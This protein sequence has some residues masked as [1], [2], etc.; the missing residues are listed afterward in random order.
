MNFVKKPQV[1]FY[2]RRRGRG[3]LSARKHIS[4]DLKTQMQISLEQGTE[5]LDLSKIFHHKEIWLEIG[6][7]GGEHLVFQA[8]RNPQ[9]GFL[10]VEAFSNGVMSL[11]RWVAKEN[12]DNVRVYEGDVRLLIPCLPANSLG[13]IFILFPDP[14][15]K[16]RHHKRRLIHAQTLQEFHRILKPQGILRIASDH[17][18]YTHWILKHIEETEY[19]K[20]SATHWE[21]RIKP[22]EDWTPTRYEIKARQAGRPPV[23]LDCHPQAVSHNP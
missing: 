18:S 5:V 20:C 14:W 17:P 15:P 12:L 23:F 6:F 7:G 8:R 22:P 2:G 13:R 11:M 4:Q 19:F 16:N 9:V 1:Q 21:H 3:L 10:G